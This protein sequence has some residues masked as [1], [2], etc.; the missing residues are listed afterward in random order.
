MLHGRNSD[1]ARRLRHPRAEQQPEQT[2][3]TSSSRSRA[4]LPGARGLLERLAPVTL[5]CRSIAATAEPASG[6]LCVAR[7]PG[8]WTERTG[9][10]RTARRGRSADPGGTAATSSGATT[11]DPSSAHPLRGSPLP[12]G[13]EVEPGADT[14]HDRHVERDRSR[15]DGGSTSPASERRAPRAGCRDELRGWPRAVCGLGRR[16]SWSLRWGRPESPCPRRA[17]RARP[18]TGTPPRAR[19]RRAL[20][21]HR[22]IRH[23]SASPR[24]ARAGFS[25]SAPVTRSRNG[26]SAQSRHP[27]DRHAVGGDY[28]GRAK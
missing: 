20:R 9:G 24:D 2:R 26:R 22:K 7:R 12:T 19:R 5:R 3:S 8:A 15:G 11:R 27:D 4:A 23:D 14:D 25:R 10:R 17:G 21:R 6:R 1:G 18:R 28:V 13:Q 16:P